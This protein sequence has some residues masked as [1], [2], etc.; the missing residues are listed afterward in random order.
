MTTGHAGFSSY[1]PSVTVRER[2]LEQAKYERM[3]THPEYRLVA[4]GEQAALRFAQIAAPKQG[5]LVIDFGCG[6]GRGGQALSQM[7]LEVHLLDFAQNCRDADVKLPF[8]LHDLTQ[9]CPIVAPYGYCT[10]VLEH[11]PPSEV[12]LVLKNILAAAEHVFFQISCEDDV[13][14]K[15]IGQPLH[16]SIHPYQWWLEK[17]K[18]FDCVIHHSEDHGS[19]C[20]FYVSAWQQGETLVEHGTLNTSEETI[21]EQ[22]KHNIAQGWQQVSPHAKS[23]AEVMILGGAASLVQFE[24]DIRRMRAEGAKL[25]TLNG[26]YHW[27]IERG[28]T[29]SAQ[30]IVDARAHNAR[31]AKPILDSC[32]Y[33]IASQCHPSVLEGLPK[34]R[35]YLWHT[36]ADGIR[37]LLQ[38]QYERWYPVPGGSTVLLRAI[39]LLR[40]LGFTRF[41]LFGC[42]SCLTQEAHHAY[43]QIENDRDVVVPVN[44]AGRMFRCHPWMA[45]QATEFMDLIRFLGDEIELEVYGEGLLA[46]ILKT[47]AQL[48]DT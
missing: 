17:F 16:L 11:I 37:D 14:G 45:A 36:G 19:Y 3:W 12:E 27:C 8:T 1:A 25:V 10:D 2:T 39:P 22:V 21:R 35:T 23:E 26:A 9:E 13:C 41:H 33:L 47:G 28:L 24:T 18:A 6:T 34:D 29:P 46:H 43:L 42:D 31:F 20:L 7:G 30:I 4:P 44:V 48:A 38:A 32:R 15:L 5:S 40:M